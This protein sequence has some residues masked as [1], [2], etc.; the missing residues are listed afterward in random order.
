MPCLPKADPSERTLRILEFLVL[1]GPVVR[2]VV[3]VLNCH[4]VSERPD[5]TEHI[6][7]ITELA[8]IPSLL[9]ALFGSHTMAKLT[10]QHVEQY[11]TVT[12]FR[13]A[14][15]SLA[16]FTAQLPLIF[17]LI[18][19]KFGIITCGPVLSALGN[20]KYINSFVLI[21]EAFLLSLLATRLLAPKKS[22]L[23]DKHPLHPQQQQSD[24]QEKM[25]SMG[26]M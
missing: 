24:A 2:A 19:V 20:A 10:A 25:L 8:A 4:F 1:Q 9:L 7:L 14:D 6:L 15:I 16:F 18:F 13:F 17:D 23:F 22:A 11:K 21:C 12:M 26:Q 3:V 5:E